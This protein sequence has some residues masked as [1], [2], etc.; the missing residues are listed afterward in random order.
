MVYAGPGIVR[1][2]NED[3]IHLLQRDGFKNVREAVGTAHAF[4]RA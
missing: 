4:A 2:I 3:L 1:R